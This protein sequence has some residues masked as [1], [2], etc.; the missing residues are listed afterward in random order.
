M[1]GPLIN[2]QLAPASATAWS[3]PKTRYRLI[4]IYYIPIPSDIPLYY[5]IVY[6]VYGNSEEVSL[7]RV[8]IHYYIDPCPIILNSGVSEIYYLYGFHNI[9]FCI[10]IRQYLYIIVEYNTFKAHKKR[11]TLPPFF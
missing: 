6:I 3:E 2:R 9:K 10:G 4:N 7:Y 11:F 8:S 5:V 1:L